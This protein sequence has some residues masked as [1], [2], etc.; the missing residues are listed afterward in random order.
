MR[1]ILDAK[2][3]FKSSGVMS[4]RRKRKDPSCLTLLTI[5]L[6]LML[7]KSPVFKTW[8]KAEC[9]LYCSSFF[10]AGKQTGEMRTKKYS[11]LDFFM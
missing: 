9:Y 7:G 10:P 5:A 4:E 3:I 8:Y 6:F 11:R 1:G 2:L